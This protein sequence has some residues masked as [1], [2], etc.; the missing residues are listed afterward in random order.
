L[1]KLAEHFDALAD[2]REQ[3]TVAK[4]ADLAAVRSD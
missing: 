3:L 1:I 2:K 4:F